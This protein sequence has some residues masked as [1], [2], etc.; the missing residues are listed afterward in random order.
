ML[1]LLLIIAIPIIL[2]YIAFKISEYKDGSCGLIMLL[3]FVILMIIGVF[4]SC[5]N[6]VKEEHYPARDDYYDIPH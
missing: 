1:A 5:I 2:Y 3:I 6:W 4:K